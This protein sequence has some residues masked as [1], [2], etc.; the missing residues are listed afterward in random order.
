[1]LRMLAGLDPQQQS[2][3]F[4]SQPPVI[5]TT[6]A[7]A[8]KSAGEILRVSGKVRVVAVPQRTIDGVSVS[9]SEGGETLALHWK[10]AGNW[11]TFEF[12]RIAKV[13]GEFTLNLTLHGLGEVWFDI[14]RHLFQVIRD[15]GHIEFIWPSPSNVQAD[16]RHRDV[17]IPRWN[18][19]AQR[20]NRIEL[21]IHSV[22]RI[23]DIFECRVKHDAFVR[24]PSKCLSTGRVTISFGKQSMN[25]HDKH[26]FSEA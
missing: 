9:D 18:I 14:G 13:D 15:S 26:S 4:L 2:P 5:V 17:S 8:V 19:A 12:Y 1:M 21:V 24:V 16:T 22:D 7:I 11:Q 3:D 25:I 20:H 23:H 6:P 10:Q